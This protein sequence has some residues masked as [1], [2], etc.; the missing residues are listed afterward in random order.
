MKLFT[1]LRIRFGIAVLLATVVTTEIFAETTGYW[2]HEEGI[3]GSIVPDGSDTVLDSSGF[4]NHMKTFSSAQAP[5]T[6]ATYTSSVSPL[7][8]R[9]GLANTLSLDFGPNPATGTEDGGGRNDDNYSDGKLINTDVFTALT[10]ELAFNMHSVNGWQ[11]LFGKDGKPLGDEVG[12]PDSPVPP[13]KVLIRDDTF[14]NDIPNQLFVEWID[15]DGEIHNLATGETVQTDTWYHV[16]FTLTA[17]D[18]ELW[19]AGETGDYILKDAISGEDF[20]GDK[21]FGGVT[22]FDNTPFTIGRGMFNN[23]VT[24]WS[25]ALIDEVRVSNS[26]LLPTE[27]LFETVPGGL[28]GDFNNDSKVDGLDFLVWQ[29]NTSVGNLSDWQNNY[30]TGGLGAISAV[31][32][33]TGLALI[34]GLIGAVSLKRRW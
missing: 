22:I 21:G 12:E 3:A 25:D 14:P 9:S 7:A 33:P 2:R 5:F 26:A 11:A 29:R 24:D 15:G 13:F 8:L 17:T 27:F 18:A 32:E 6:A 23:G 1:Q 19:V 31:P 16:A 20:A 28:A 34:C 4:A 10:V 30:G